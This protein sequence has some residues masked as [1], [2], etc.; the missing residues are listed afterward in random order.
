[1]SGTYQVQPPEPFSFSR[2]NEWPKWARR[3]ERFRVASGLGSQGEEVQ[4]NTLLY[5]MG[6]DADDILRS[7]QLSTAD[8]KKYSEVKG[9]FDQHFVKKRNVIFERARFNRRKQ[10][11]SETVDAFITDLYALAEH[12]SYTG[13][14]DEM[15]R[16]RL[17]VGLLSAS[18]SEQLQLDP[19]LTLEK[20]ITKAR[21]AEAIKLQQPLIRG[22]GAVK[23]DL[24]VGAV[25]QG[26]PSQNRS[27]EKG[28]N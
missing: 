16:D 13:L 20:A 6:D 2:P 25:Q 24:P 7:F 8:Q 22:E 4:V 19:A 11:E 9:R 12:C 1:M 14:H 10:E 3:F 27:R 5:A 28:A 23:P 15:I 17:V 18:L 26:R 21:Q